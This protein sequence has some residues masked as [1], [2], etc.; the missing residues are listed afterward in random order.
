MREMPVVSAVVIVAIHA[1][2]RDRIDHR[3]SPAVHATV[4]FAAVCPADL[5]VEAN[6][7]RDDAAVVQHPLA[8]GRADVIE[9]PASV[10][11]FMSEHVGVNA[12]LV[13]PGLRG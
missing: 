11:F 1:P 10:A 2:A 5:A 8:V 12:R 6:V 7:G 4:P 9:D 13:A 3:E